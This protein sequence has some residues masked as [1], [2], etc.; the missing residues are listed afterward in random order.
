MQFNRFASTCMTLVNLFS[1][2]LSK[3]YATFEELWISD[4]TC[5]LLLPSLLLGTQMRIGQTGPQQGGPLQ[6]IV[7]LWETTSCPGL[8]SASRLSLVP[9][10]RLNTKSSGNL[11]M[12]GNEDHH[13]Q[14]RRFAA[15]GN[16]HD[17]RDPR[18]VK[19][20]RLHQRIRD[21]EIQHEI[22]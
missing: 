16:R 10:L 3:Y 9:V 21:L 6:V 5:T 13:R 4:F 19:I 17:G 8:L 22:R 11:K 18:D 7:F 14:G 12:S 20:E 2:P 1:L 15:G